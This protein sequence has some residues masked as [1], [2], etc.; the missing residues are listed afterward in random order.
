[1]LRAGRRTRP[2]V[3]VTNGQDTGNPL[4]YVDARRQTRG[5]KTE[6]RRAPVLPLF[7]R[8]GR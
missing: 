8:Y 4:V 3:I 6:D 1:M 5:D 2:Y 7:Y